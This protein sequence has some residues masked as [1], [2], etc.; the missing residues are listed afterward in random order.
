MGWSTTTEVGGIFSRDENQNPVWANAN[1]A[2]VRYCSSDAWMGDAEA[3]GMQFRGQTLV[4]ATLRDLQERQGLS[5][6][7]RLLFGGCSAGARG[8]MTHLDALAETLAA[9]GVEVRGML[10]SSLW[11]DVQ[12]TSSTALGGS[13]LD[14]AQL[15]YEFANTTGVL[16]PECAAQYPNA[17]WKC[18]FGQYRM[19]LLR[20][21]Y[22]LSQSQFD[23]FQVDYDCSSTSATDEAGKVTTTVTPAEVPCVNNFQAT[24]RS[25]LQQLPAPGQA[26]S[27]IF[28]STCS[29][30]CV[31]NG[32][33]WWTIQVG[34]QSMAS[35]MTAWSFGGDTP[36]VV[37]PCIGVDC[38]QQCL[39][40]EQQFP[41][42]DFG[43]AGK[44]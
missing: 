20:T 33:D 19:P 44:S 1:F 32:P 17:P 22:F 11:V 42:G 26:S 34:G 24:M 41:S 18:M 7:A 4:Y 10:D 28:A 27:G 14:Q 12:P 36:Y 8:A 2:Y 6:G 37:D 13:L 30:H 25:V 21:P 31:T 15:V 38:M 9:D 5:A 43:S 39:P 23:D 29:L 3:F 40:E 35:L 16:S